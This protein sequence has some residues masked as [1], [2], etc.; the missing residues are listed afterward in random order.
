MNMLSYFS[1][2]V[3]TRLDPRQLNGD[4][5]TFQFGQTLD[6]LLVSPALAGRPH[7]DSGQEWRGSQRIIFDK[8]TDDTEPGTLFINEEGNWVYG[9]LDYRE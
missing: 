1:G 6:L 2:L 7:H 5:G 9:D 8:F 3:P 4:D